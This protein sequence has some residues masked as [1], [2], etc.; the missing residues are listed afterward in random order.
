MEEWTR[1]KM[2]KH[3]FQ[4]DLDDHCQRGC[5]RDGSK[6]FAAI[7]WWAEVASGMFLIR[8]RSLL[9]H[10]WDTMNIVKATLMP[11]LNDNIATADDSEHNNVHQRQQILIKDNNDTDQTK[12]DQ[13]LSLVPLL[14]PLLAT[15]LGLRR[16]PVWRWFHPLYQRYFLI[17]IIHEIVWSSWMKICFRTYCLALSLVSHSVTP[18]VRALVELSSNWI[19]YMNL[20]KLIHWHPVWSNHK[21]IAAILKITLKRSLRLG[22]LRGW[23]QGLNHTHPW[24]KSCQFFYET[25]LSG[26]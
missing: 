9:A 11:I 15:A 26:P 17:K 14:R 20:S 4:P 7:R 2:L 12:R 10:R 23:L 22:H 19:C 24:H 13:I 16:P 25:S 3:I 18:W 8:L 6:P 5:A 1:S 21:I